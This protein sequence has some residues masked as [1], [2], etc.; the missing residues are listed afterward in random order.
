LAIPDLEPEGFL[1][2]GIHAASLSEVR[3]CSGLASA[4]RQRQSEPLSQIVEAAGVYPTIK[5]VLVWGSFVSAKVEPNDLDYSV[6]VSVSH[7]R[8][9]IAPAHRRLFVPADARRCYG[10]DKS[11]LV[12]K[13]YPLDVYVERV[14]FVCRN[15]AM[16]PCGILEISIRGEITGEQS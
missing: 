1:P 13:D 8:V 6:I 4:A 12:I 2:P 3:A 16:Q 9:P 10:V 14:D 5:R 7:N 15:C 11:Y